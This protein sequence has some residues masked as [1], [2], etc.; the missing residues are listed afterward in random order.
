MRVLHLYSGN[1]YGGVERMLT[2]LAACRHLAPELE[3]E[4]A[5]CFRGQL[6]DELTAAGAPVHDLGRV[7]VSRPWT[8][9]RARRRLEGVLAATAADVV[10]CHC[11]WP[12]AL[13]GPTALRR[14]RRLVYWAH[15]AGLHGGPARGPRTWIEWLA[16]RV[17]PDLTVA[18]SEYTR[19]FAAAL[20][21]GVRCEV[22]FY[23][24]A[25]QFPADRAAV[26]AAV[27]RAT[28]T[29]AGD[30]VILQTSR[31][32]EYKGHRLLLS[33]LGR[34]RDL[35]GW[36]CWVAGGPGRPAEHGYLD[37]LKAAAAREGV[38]DRVR[39][40]GHRSD[41]PSLLVAADVLCQPNTGPEPFGIAFVEGLAA[42]LPVVST[43][44]GAAV[45]VLGG[46]AGVLVPPGDPDRLAAALREL[47]LDPAA[48]RRFADT[49][50]PRTAELC[51]P[52]RRMADLARLLAPPL[53]E[54]GTT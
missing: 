16:A 47:I 51:D 7:R 50:P 2:T 11:C 12:L 35:P 29:A 17:R 27:R 40:L 3:P 41:V 19:P 49:G 8:V 32:V 39:F 43:A 26:R 45:E 52:A 31:L 23:P 5:L 54:V 48:R 36:V 28:D 25:L 13:F 42:G 38:A 37:G 21:P 4:F 22:Q 10:V 15:D 20:H 9:W 46:G 30:V 18:I 44:M 53:S 6:W 24:A 1:L 14:G 34:L 33:A